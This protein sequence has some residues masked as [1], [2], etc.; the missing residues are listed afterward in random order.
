MTLDGLQPTILLPA[1]AAG[2]LVLASHVPL[3]R[4]VLRRGIIFID[5]AIAQI[6]GLGIVIA[7]TLGFEVNGWRTQLSAVIAAL[8][9]ALCL[10]WME[11][12]NPAHLEA[13]I[14]V[15]F[16]A[17]ACAAILLMSHDPHAGEHL[18]DLLVGQIL[19]T[20]WAGLLPLALV[21][22][23]VLA[24]WFGGNLKA[25]PLGFY[26]LF[27]LTITASVQVVGVYLVFASLIVPA[28]AAG[29]LWR[30]YAIGIA[31]Y[32]MGLTASGLLDLPAGATVVLA[33]VVVAALS[34]A[35]VP[36]GNHAQP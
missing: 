35:L 11:K 22:A 23:G 28:L 3:G 27:A 14:G 4:E 25:S 16:V 2:L 36:A 13:V 8:A 19:W 26:L 29:R 5:L 21:T 12:K 33:L 10:R 17:A 34:A 31:G 18:Q 1:F 32:A 30:A 9:G 6:A 20:T 15:S 7:S 24:G